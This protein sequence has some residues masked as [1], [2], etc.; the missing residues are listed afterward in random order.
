MPDV[1]VPGG[2]ATARSNRFYGAADLADSFALAPAPPTVTWAKEV[3]LAPKQSVEIEVPVTAAPN[4]GAVFMAS[5][6]IS[7]TLIDNN[8]RVV[9]TN[10]AGSPESRGWFRSIFVNTPV[11]AATWKIRF[12]NTSDRDQSAIAATGGVR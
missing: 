7:I 1:Q 8:G 10:A 3:K 12:E 4:F 11:T 9:G 6:D 2:M 5:S